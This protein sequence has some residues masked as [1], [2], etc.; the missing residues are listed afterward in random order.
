[1]TRQYKKKFILFPEHSS[2]VNAVSISPD[3]T[4]IASGGA[5]GNVY[6]FSVRSGEEIRTSTFQAHTSAIGH[7][8]P[9]PDA[10]VLA[11]AAQGEVK[12]W[13]QTIGAHGK[14]HWRFPIIIPQPP[15]EIARVDD[16]ATVTGLR[17]LKEA[18]RL[19]NRSD[20]SLVV[21]YLWHGIICWG[22]NSL[23]PQW[24]IAHRGCF[25][26]DL[27]PDL[28]TLAVHAETSRFDI[29]DVTSRMKLRSLEVEKGDGASI[30][31]SSLP[32]QFIHDG[33]AVLGGSYVGNVRIWDLETG[34]R[35]QVL[36]HGAVTIQSLAAYYVI[37]SREFFIITGS[38]DGR[39]VIW[40][41]I[42]SRV[43]VDSR[44]SDRPTN[45]IVKIPTSLYWSLWVF[46]G[47]LLSALAFNFMNM[48]RR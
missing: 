14:E 4:R 15:P 9:I 10:M 37:P 16:A 33:L 23:A 21:S 32:V 8:A 11:S 5:D 18:T 39:V 12:I 3:G 47:L 45:F 34:D 25:S 30:G 43:E 46:S 26:F 42:A 29:Y 31:Q 41:T 2:P 44:D 20:G 17:W 28:S 27:S 40:E 38:S 24:R 19:D 35:L 6:I 22:L 13:K 48:Y 36:R 7:M 1:M